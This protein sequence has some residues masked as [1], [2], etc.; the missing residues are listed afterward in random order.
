MLSMDDMKK[1]QP[2]SGQLDIKTLLASEC[3]DAMKNGDK[4]KFVA[5][6]KDLVSICM[7]EESNGEDDGENS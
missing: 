5:R 4:Q 2:S 6:I 7:M 3:F 1:Q